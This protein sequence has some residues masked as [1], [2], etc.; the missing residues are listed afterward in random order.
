MLGV[1]D[2]VAGTNVDADAEDGVVAHL[3]IT[4]APQVPW[5][6]RLATLSILLG[7]TRSF[8]PC[9]EYSDKCKTPISPIYTK[10]KNWNICF[11]CGF[12]I[13]DGHTSLTCPFNKMNQQSSFTCKNAQQ[14]I[15]GGYDPC[16]KGMHK[17]V[18]PLRWH[19]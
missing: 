12:D 15:A 8:C 7:A 6:L 5:R 11:S 9:R 10:G 19:T 14:F 2:I 4:C 18:L 13:E 1:G 3:L 17:T 16:T